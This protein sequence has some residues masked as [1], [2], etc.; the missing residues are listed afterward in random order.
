MRSA[1]ADLRLGRLVVIYPGARRYTLNA[2]AE[3][4]P[5]DELA[6]ATWTSLFRR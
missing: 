5:V 1:M 6:E 3:V 2:R 4:V